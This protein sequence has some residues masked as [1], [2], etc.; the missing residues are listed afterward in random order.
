MMCL[1]LKIIEA[2]ILDIFCYTKINY[3]SIAGKLSRNVFDALS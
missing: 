3:R 2:A 1:Q